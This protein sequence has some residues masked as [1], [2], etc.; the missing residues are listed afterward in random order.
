M[1]SLHPQNRQDGSQQPQPLKGA[2][3]QNYGRYCRHEACCPP[4]ASPFGPEP[5]ETEGAE[6]EGHGC[7]IGVEVPDRIEEV[8]RI[9][10]HEHG[11]DGGSRHW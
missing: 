4:A 3:A 2:V 6:G 5:G 1:A 10:Y 8:G 11:D 9:E 7:R